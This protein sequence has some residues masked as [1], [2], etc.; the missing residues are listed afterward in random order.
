MHGC[1]CHT[2]INI[3]NTAYI[4]P[5]ISFMNMAEHMQSGFY[6]EDRVQ[7]IAVA[8]GFASD[9]PIANAVGRGVRYENV[10]ARWNERPFFAQCRACLLYTSPSPRDCS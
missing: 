4:E 7:Q 10:D 9:S 2:D 3:N 8:D 1:I 5:A 6:F